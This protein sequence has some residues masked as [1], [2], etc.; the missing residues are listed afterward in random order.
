M[1]SFLRFFGRPT[2][3]FLSLSILVSISA[4]ALAA[5]NPT[6][7][8]HNTLSISGS[9]EFTSLDPS[10]NGYIYTRMQVL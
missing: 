10:K 6:P 1:Q 8:S 4:S 3:F 7:T 9:F 5:D 2:R